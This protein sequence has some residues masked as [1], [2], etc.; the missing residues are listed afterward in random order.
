MP[1]ICA[2]WRRQVRDAD[3]S[4][5]D[6]YWHALRRPSCEVSR[7]PPHVDGT[8]RRLTGRLRF[9]HEDFVVTPCTPSESAI[10]R[11]WQPSWMLCFARTSRDSFVTIRHP[12]VTAARRTWDRTTGTMYMSQGTRDGWA[13]ASRRHGGRSLFARTDDRVGGLRGLADVV[14][15]QA[16]DFGKLHDLTCHR[17]L[18]RP[19]VGCVLVQGEMGT[20]LMVVGEVS[21]QDAAE[22]SLAENEHVIQ[23]LAPDRA[24]EPFRKGIVT[25]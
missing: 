4:L 5:V 20:R 16:A 25:V 7:D 15:V 23:A 3:W 21:G 10:P 6:R 18:D 12:R 24:D 2:D 13:R 9:H 8:D 22:V 19:E 11:E 17:E 14:V 1:A